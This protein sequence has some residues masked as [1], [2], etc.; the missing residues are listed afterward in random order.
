MAVRAGDYKLVRYDSN[1]DT[2]TGKG[3]QPVTAARLYDLK[4][5]LGE[6][7]DLAASMPEKVAELQ[8]QWDRW[9]QQNMPP[10]WGGGNKVASDGEP[11]SGQS[12]K[13]SQKFEKSEKRAKQSTSGESQ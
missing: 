12:G 7:R 3:K 10:L 9:N 8:A 5:D 1:A 13:A 11:R 4:E 6:T 2:L